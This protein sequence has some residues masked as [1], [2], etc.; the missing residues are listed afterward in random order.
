[1]IGNDIVDIVEAARKSDW[2]RKGFLKK[3]FTAKE[4]LRISNSDNPD[5]IVWLLWSMKESAYKIYLRLQRKYFVSPLK[6][7]SELIA[8]LNECY[9]GKVF[10]EN[11]TYLTNS[12]VT[13]EFVSTTALAEN[14]LRKGKIF[15]K[16]LKFSNEDFDKHREEIYSSISETFSEKINK[17]SEK[18]SIKK[19]N[20]GIP[21]IFDGQRQLD[22]SVSISH[23]GRYG[24]YAFIF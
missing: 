24:A 10:I 16:D 20:F 4:Q 21:Y 13:K 14:K 12:K 1:M 7:E 5:L 18:I 6:L 23:H 15:Q 3:V 2:R 11:F 9:K 17:P 22:T 19:D 8:D